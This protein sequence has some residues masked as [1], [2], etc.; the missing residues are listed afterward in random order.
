M[1]R[2]TESDDMMKVKDGW[3][4][5]VVEWPD[6]SRNTVIGRNGFDAMASPGGHYVTIGEGFV[7]A[8]P[9][10]GIDGYAHFET[11]E[12]AHAYLLAQGSDSPWPHA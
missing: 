9:H 8:W 2:S 3:E 11:I 7:E 10:G 5:R 1:M 4:C 12:E 6:G